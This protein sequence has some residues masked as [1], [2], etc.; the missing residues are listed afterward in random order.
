MLELS[1]VPSV[2]EGYDIS[3]SQGSDTVASKV[4]FIDGVPV[5]SLYRRYKLKAQAIAHGK[6][7]DYLSI[8]EVLTRRFA[9]YLQEDG[10]DH[11]SSLPGWEKPQKNKKNKDRIP[12]IVLIDGGKGQLSAAEEVVSSLNFHGGNSTILLS[13]AKQKEEVFVVGR[14]NAVNTNHDEATPAMMILRQVRDEAHR[15]ANSYHRS[16]RNKNFLQG[17]SDR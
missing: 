11:A 16:L 8:K 15:Y 2:V 10:G 12:D 7:D 1:V 4:V 13:L 14:V 3:H 9:D 6:V 17:R 5:K